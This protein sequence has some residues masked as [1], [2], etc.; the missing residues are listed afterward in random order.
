MS[1]P[2]CGKAHRGLVVVGVP[3]YA[4]ALTLTGDEQQEIGLYCGTVFATV[5]QP[6]R[7]CNSPHYGAT[8]IHIVAPGTYNP[9]TNPSRIMPRHLFDLALGANSLWEKD[10]YSLGGKLTVVNVTNQVALYN[11]LSSFSGTHFVTPRIIQGELMF[12]F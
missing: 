6:L 8:L 3:D 7:G 10:N 12:H 5:D 11:F 9:D 4:T 2:T 1:V